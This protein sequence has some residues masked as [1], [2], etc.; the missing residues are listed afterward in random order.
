MIHSFR[1][2]ETE[3]LFATG[4]SRKFQSIKTVG[5]RKLTMID[6]AETIEFLLSPPGNRLEQL[7]RDRKGE[8]SIRINKQWRICFWFKDGKA[9]GVEIVDYH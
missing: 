2:R 4:K 9:T 8:W 7:S 5:E 1:C 6:A 3:K